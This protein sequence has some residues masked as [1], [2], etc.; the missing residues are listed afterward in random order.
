[1]RKFL[2]FIFGKRKKLAS[3]NQLEDKLWDEIRDQ[4]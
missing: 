2:E 3:T 1:M 4:L